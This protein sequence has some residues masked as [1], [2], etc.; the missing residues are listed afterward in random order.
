[1][2]PSLS[3]FLH[4]V[5][6]VPFH[7]PARKSIHIRHRSFTPCL[8]IQSEQPIRVNTKS[9]K[10]CYCSNRH[11]LYPPTIRNRI[12]SAFLSASYSSIIPQSSHHQTKSTICTNFKFSKNQTQ[13]VGHSSTVSPSTRSWLRT[14]KAPASVLIDPINTNTPL[15]LLFLENHKGHRRHRRRN[16]PPLEHLWLEDKGQLLPRGQN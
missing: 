8:C 13:C 14:A 7:T 12:S 10:Q 6:Q 2:P 4:S 1:M 16:Q 5:S 15:A 3:L 9:S 11:P